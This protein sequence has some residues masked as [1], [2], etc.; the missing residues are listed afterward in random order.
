MAVVANTA[1]IGSVWLNEKAGLTATPFLT[2]VAI[3]PAYASGWPVIPLA[4]PLNFEMKCDLERIS[5][6]RPHRSSEAVTIQNAAF[7]IRRI[8]RQPQSCMAP[9]SANISRPKKSSQPLL[10]AMWLPQLTSPG[11]SPISPTETQSGESPA[12][13][14]ASPKNAFDRSP[15]VVI[16]N[17]ET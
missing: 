7:W 4:K 16:Q 14:T 3:V 5:P 11:Q 15:A 17:T 13:T 10:V 12:V 2:A 1:M 6:I 8:Q 9:A